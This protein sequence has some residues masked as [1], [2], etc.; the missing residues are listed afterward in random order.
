MRANELPDLCVPCDK[1]DIF[2]QQDPPRSRRHA[3]GALRLE[4]EGHA[5][6]ASRSAAEGCATLRTWGSS[7]SRSNAGGGVLEVPGRQLVLYQPACPLG[8]G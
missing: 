4:V 7:H 3:T 5:T 1:P 6:E 2:R 8:V